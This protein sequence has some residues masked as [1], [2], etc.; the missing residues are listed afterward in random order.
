MVSQLLPRT[1]CRSLQRNHSE[2][3]QQEA[4][5]SILQAMYSGVSDIQAEGEALG[6][7]GDN[8]SNVNTVGFKEQRSIFEDMLN[9]SITADTATSLPRSGVKMTNIQQLFTQGSL[10]NTNVSTDVALSDD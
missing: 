7:V 4:K 9:H 8:I 3:G 5:M 2:E 10:S 1:F 6:V